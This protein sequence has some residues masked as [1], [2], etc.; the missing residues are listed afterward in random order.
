MSDIFR[1]VDEDLKKERLLQIWRNYSI[2]IISFLILLIFFSAG[3]Q[4]Y[5]SYNQSINEQIVIDYIKTTNLENSDKF[6][7]KV[8]LIENNSNQ[9]IAALTKLRI[10]DHFAEKG[11]DDEAE[12]KLLEIIE[13]EVFNN[14]MR[15]HAL[16]NYIMLNI[17]TLE[18]KEIEKYIS[19]YSNENSNLKPLFSELLAIKYLLSGKA[20]ESKELFKNL[21]NNPITNSYIRLRAEKFITILENV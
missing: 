9:L 17:D 21:I 10:S 1:L 3:Y 18:V 16:Y 4:F 2:Y 12:R 14:T 19:K 20:V 13:S 7:E 5:K 15:E 6:L 11:E 8:E